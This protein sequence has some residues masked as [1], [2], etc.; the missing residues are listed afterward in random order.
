MSLFYKNYNDLTKL[1]KLPNGNVN[2]YYQNTNTY[3]LH[4]NKDYPFK[5]M[6]C[7]H[8][9]NYKNNIR[10]QPNDKWNRLY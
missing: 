7:K 4:Q 1:Q 3:K 6:L 2:N 9:S 10:K 8:C 5:Y